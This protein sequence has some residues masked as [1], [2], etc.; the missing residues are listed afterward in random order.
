MRKSGV[1][2][3][4]ELFRSLKPKHGS[5]SAFLVA[6]G[7]VMG[8]TLVRLLLDPVVPGYRSLLAI[9]VLA[10][11]FAVLLGGVRAATL[12]LVASTAIY[13]WLFLPPRHSF[14]I[15]SI[16]DAARLIAF[17]VIG[18]FILW[19]AQRYRRIIES[20]AEEVAF[21]KLTTERLQIGEERL[22]LATHA[23]GLGI[24]D[25]DAV[26]DV[27]VWSPELY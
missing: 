4:Q 20:L 15:L 22:R 9:Y 13:W 18:A 12:A 23:S 8:V 27:V 17:V 2:N 26:G 16:I 25:Y 10:V 14:V 19:G 7:C 5:I 11:L 21:R 3:L 24:L 1:G 6:L